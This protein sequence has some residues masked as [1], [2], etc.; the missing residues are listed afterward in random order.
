MSIKSKSFKYKNI[1]LVTGSLA[2]VIFLLRDIVCGFNY[3]GYSWA[4]KFIAD[5]ATVSSNSYVLSL[6]FMIVAA[7][8]VVFAMFLIISYHIAF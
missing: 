6:C 4:D 8:L 2:L 5:F 7:V 3:P 1:V